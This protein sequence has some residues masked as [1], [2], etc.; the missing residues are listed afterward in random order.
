MIFEHAAMREGCTVCHSPHGSINAKMLVQR[1]S[2]LCLKCHAQR[3][4]NSSNRAVVYIGNVD[5]GTFMRYGTCWTAGCHA[6]VHG[7]NTQPFYFY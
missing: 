3:Q 2:N 6:A 5:H 4:E 1:D 7:S